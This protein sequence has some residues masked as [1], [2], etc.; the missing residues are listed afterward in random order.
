MEAPVHFVN[1]LH[2]ESMEQDLVKDFWN[3]VKATVDRVAAEERQLNARDIAQL[4]MARVMDAANGHQASRGFERSYRSQIDKV[5]TV[6]R[7]LEEN[8]MA[9]CRVESIWKRA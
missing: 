8:G 1:C 5:R 7:L 4:E 2:K 6:Q 3:S 9:T